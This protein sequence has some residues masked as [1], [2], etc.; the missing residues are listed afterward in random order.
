MKHIS[1]AVLSLLIFAAHAQ[2]AVPDGTMISSDVVR[3]I[4]QWVEGATGKKV[5]VM[6]MV[7]ASG[8]RLKNS[9][10]LEGVQQA[11][12]VAAYIP[13]QIII[14]HIQWDPESI[15]SVSY[16]VHEMVHHAQTLSGQKYACNNAKEGEAY[17]LQNRWLKEHGEDPIYDAEW[18]KDIA[19]CDK[20]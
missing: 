1:F 14:N 7:V 12:S 17:T 8:T 6:P 9:L 19:T 11:R 20:S 2:A 10:G 5:R 13:G 15:N 16:M 18:I 4:A 3:P